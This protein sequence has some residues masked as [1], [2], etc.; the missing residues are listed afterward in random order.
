MAPRSESAEPT[1]LRHALASAA[2]ALRPGGWCS[3]LMEGAD[4]DRI[5]SVAVAGAAAELDLVDVIHRESIRSG[6]AVTLHFHKPSEEDRLREAVLP[7][8]LQLGAEDGHLT[9]P[10]LAEAIDRAATA[11]LRER[12]EPAGLVRIAAAV[13]VELQRSGLLRRIAASRGGVPQLADR[14]E[15]EEGERPLW[16][17]RQEELAESPLADRVEWAAVS[18]LATAGRLDE[19]AFLERVY[20]LFPG[21]QA[22]DEELVRACLAAYASA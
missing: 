5:L 16:W 4:L 8:A 7:D 14:G 3:M 2:E 15:V 20:A 12:G 22:P 10:E 6:D 19:A 18:I 13:L 21:L 9:Y 1:A 11:L 17:L